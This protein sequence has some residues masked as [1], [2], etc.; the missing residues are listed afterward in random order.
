MNGLE[1]GGQGGEGAGQGGEGG[2]EL[3]G[4]GVLRQAPG[5]ALLDEPLAAP[6]SSMA[7]AI[8]WWRR[9]ASMAAR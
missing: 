3:G 9:L 4:G 7:A 5:G 2:V 8:P 1:H 6:V